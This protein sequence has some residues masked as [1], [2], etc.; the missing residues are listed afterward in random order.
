MPPH[1]L[2]ENRSEYSKSFNVLDYTQIVDNN[3]RLFLNNTI[4]SKLLSNI[5]HPLVLM[6]YLV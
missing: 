5:V 4:L 1:G 2:L 3:Q 6:A